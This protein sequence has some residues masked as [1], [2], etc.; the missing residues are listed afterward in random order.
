[1]RK[2]ILFLYQWLIFVPLFVAVTVITTFFVIL[3]C[4]LGNR[5]FWAY[6]PP[7]W[8][9]K[10]VCFLA[11]CKVKV[12]G[13]EHLQTGQTYVFTPNHQSYLDIFVVYGYLPQ[14][15]K[16]VQKQALRQLPFVGKA[17][18][19]AGHIFVDQSS[20]ASRK[21]S[22]IEAEKQL[23]E[24][25]GVS[26][27]IFPEGA[28]SHTGKLAKF[29]RGAFFIAQQLSLPIVPVTLNGVYDV[30]PRHSWLLS[31]GCM[32]LIIH[33]PINTRGVSE[34]EISKLTLETQNIVESA[35]WQQYRTQPTTTF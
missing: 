25:P 21:A 19:M 10:A 4:T 6:T 16:W 29:K 17:S 31:P 28:R 1:M 8:W 24:E 9:G 34:E 12:S 23:R 33:P 3:G 7:K 26:L 13:L 20:M 30:L 15:I 5:S 32:E 27:A 22:I 35:L 11:L 18:A 2:V 14:N